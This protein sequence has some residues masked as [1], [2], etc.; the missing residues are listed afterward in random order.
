LGAARQSPA[1]VSGFLLPLQQSPKVTVQLT[2]SDGKCWTAD[3]S[4]P[5]RL[6]RT[7]GFFD[8]GD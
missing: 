7:D 1:L 6:N 8:K 2:N 5:A 3:Y 4:A